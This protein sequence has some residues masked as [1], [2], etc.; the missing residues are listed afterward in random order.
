MAAG[1]LRFGVENPKLK[2]GAY[3]RDMMRGRSPAAGMTWENYSGRGPSI[4]IQNARGEKRVVEVVK[5][6]KE[7]RD[8]ATTIER[9]YKT[10]DTAAWCERYSVPT[11]FVSE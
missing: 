7:A 9:E 2:W 4:V 3:F 5:S 1:T 8:R 6:V 10:L 11:S